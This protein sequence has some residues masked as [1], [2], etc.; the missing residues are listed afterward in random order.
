M[1]TTARM[2][3]ITGIISPQVTLPNT[4]LNECRLTRVAPSSTTKADILHADKGDKQTNAGCDGALN[5]LRNGFEDELAETGDGQEDE[6]E[7]VNK[8]I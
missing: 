1:T 8:R 2:V 7:A 5:R 6:D 3:T 4:M